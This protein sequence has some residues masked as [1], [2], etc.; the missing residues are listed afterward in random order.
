MTSFTK[1]SAGKTSWIAVFVGM[2]LLTLS[3]TNRSARADEFEIPIVD[4]HVHLWDLK[5]PE[6]IYW[7][8]KDNKFLYRSML[9]ET[10]EAIAKANQVQGVVIVQAGQSLPD[11]QWNLDITAHNKEL[12]RGVV[13]NLSEV[14]GTKDFQPLFSKLC[15]DKRYVGYRLSGRYKDEK[16]IS[17]ELIRDLKLTAKSGKTVDFLVGRYSL[18]DVAII[19]Q[20]VP[21]LKIIIDHFGNVRLNGKPLDKQ[22]VEQLKAVA[23]NKN[24]YCKVSA[25]Y[26]RANS[27]PAPRDIEF[28]R[29]VLDLV[30]EN[31][32]EDRLV[33]GS[34]WPV[35]RSS[36]D[37]AS[38]IKLTRAYFDKK[39]RR[40]SEKLF[41]KNAVKFYGIEFP[42]PAPETKSK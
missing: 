14:I 19:A 39:G 10:H 20:R 29:P 24:V 33:Y 18:S 40:I 15:K 27:K 42:Y 13:G 6:G 32:G 36:G 9:P 2:A 26:G 21:N 38:V 8:K 34:D 35:T 25:L 31:F 23:K 7:I 11:N 1:S 12:Y 5:R 41:Y 3:L 37:Y 30:M 16:E 22:W 4:T 28:Y 17:D